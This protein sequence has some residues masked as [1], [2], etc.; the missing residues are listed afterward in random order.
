MKSYCVKTLRQE[1]DATTNCE[2]VSQSD[3]NNII[4]SGGRINTRLNAFNNNFDNNVDRQN[5]FLDVGHHFKDFPP[6]CGSILPN[7]V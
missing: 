6:D 2:S 4:L 3:T 5:D 7:H 1:R